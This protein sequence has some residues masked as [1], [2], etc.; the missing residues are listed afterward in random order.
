MTHSPPM[1]LRLD[2]TGK[3]VAWTHW[4]EAVYLYTRDK[5]VW[6]MGEED[7]CIHGGINRLSGERSS[8]TINSIIAV[9]SN[10]RHSAFLTAVPPLTNRELFHRDAH[11]CLYCGEE[12]P[13]RLLTRDHVVPLNQGGRDTWSNLVTACRGCNS[14][15][16]GR[17]PE[18][19]RMPL[20]AIPYV[21]NWAEYLFLTNR[22]ILADQMEFLRAQFGRNSRLSRRQGQTTRLS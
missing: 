6:S 12:L 18:Q 7:F 2:I 17:T 13:S 11:M 15:K 4:Q 10:T 1:I 8:V 21:P 20:L 16:G 5:V 14:R 22:R 3:P 9:R 19:A